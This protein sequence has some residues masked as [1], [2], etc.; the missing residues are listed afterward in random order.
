[1]LR[2]V[3]ALKRV[4]KGEAVTPEGWM[5]GEAILLPP[6]VDPASF[7]KS[8]SDPLWFYRFRDDTK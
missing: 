1:M 6:P 3:A 7:E 8:V 2:I 5:P 4:D